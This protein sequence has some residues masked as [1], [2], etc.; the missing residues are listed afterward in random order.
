MPGQVQLVLSVGDIMIDRVGPNKRTIML[1][2]GSTGLLE[3]F[4]EKSLKIKICLEKCW[5]IRQMP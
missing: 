3:G 1:L 5:K 2:Q 4:L